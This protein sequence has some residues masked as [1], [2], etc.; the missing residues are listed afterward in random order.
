MYYELFIT[1]RKSVNSE[2]N[3]ENIQFPSLRS[4][5]E[6]AMFE[7]KTWTKIIVGAT[8]FVASLF[9]IMTISNDLLAYV[10][11]SLL[12]AV[13]VSFFCDATNKR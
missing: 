2:K 5:L 13:S 10:L 12:L 9:S 11:T 1:T 6:R 7:T 8:C 4:A 3:H